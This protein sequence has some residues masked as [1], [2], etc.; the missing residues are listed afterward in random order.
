M[1]V[2]GTQLDVLRAIVDIQKITSAEEVEDI[3][4]AEEID[5]DINL[6]RNALDTLAEAG[7]V[8][9]EKVET[10]SGMVYNTFHTKQ[11][12]AALEESLRM[13]SDRLA[14]LS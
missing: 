12:K 7:Y 14:R 3:Q 4:I 13:V 9:L 10:L 6:V 5:L 2:Q 11:G 1:K 8:R